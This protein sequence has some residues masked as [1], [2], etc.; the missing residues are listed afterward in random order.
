MLHVATADPGWILDGPAELKGRGP[1]VV[2]R[3]ESLRTEERVNTV[4]RKQIMEK[5]SAAEDALL[6]QR[7]KEGDH[8]AAR[9][10]TD[11]YL[12]RLVAYATRMLGDPAEAEDVAQDAFVRLWRNLDKWQPEKPLIHWLQRVTHNLC[13]DRIRKRRTLDIDAIPEPEDGQPSSLTLVHRSE[14]DQT[15]QTAILALPDR[16]RAAIL[17]VHQEG[18]NNIETAELM[19]ISVEAVESLLARGRR[20]LRQSLAGLVPELK[21]VE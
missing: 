16:Q 19:D 13:I 15:V 9:Q 7:L 5:S 20:S 8:K 11:V 14:I 6:V 1:K 2:R 17:F 21:G 18:H 3:W 4:E 12:D 10:V